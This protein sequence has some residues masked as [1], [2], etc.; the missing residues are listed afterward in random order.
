MTVTST[1]SWACDMAPDL[2]R[3]ISGICGMGTGWPRRFGPGYIVVAAPPVG[4]GCGGA[5]ASWRGVNLTLGA[6]R[7]MVPRSPCWLA[8]PDRPDASQAHALKRG[9][10]QETVCT[11]PAQV[12]VAELTQS[13]RATRRPMNLSPRLSPCFPIVASRALCRCVCLSRCRVCEWVAGGSASQPESLCGRA[14]DGVVAPASPRQVAGGAAGWYDIVLT[15]IPSPNMVSGIR[16]MAIT[17]AIARC[18]T[19][20]SAAIAPSMCCGACAMAIGWGGAKI[21]FADDW[22]QQCAQR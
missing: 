11:G 14:T 22:H 7:V 18:S 20:A 10:A 2:R 12:S 19:W 8:A 13:P 6:N 21:G 15:V 1:S 5:L 9:A 17:S 16:S 3:C 4:L